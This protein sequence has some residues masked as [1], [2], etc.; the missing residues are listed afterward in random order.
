MRGGARTP[1]KEP[2]KTE[3]VR[4][5]QYGLTVQDISLRLVIS[6]SAV[7]RILR[8]RNI[9]YRKPSWNKLPDD[10]R[11]QAV[12][13]YVNEKHTIPE[14]A[15]ILGISNT[16]VARWLKAENVTRPMGEA[17]AIAVQKGRKKRAKSQNI[18][19]QSSK[20]GRWEFADSRWEVVRMSQLDTDQTVATWTR[21]VDRIPYVDK[22]GKNRY[23]APD[24][25]IVYTDGSRV[26][27]EIKPIRFSESD[28]TKIK[29][30][31]AIAAFSQLGINY[32]LVTE[33]MIGIDNI[34]KFTLDGLASITDEQRKRSRSK[35]I[36][37]RSKK[38]RAPMVQEKR[39]RFMERAK[40]AA[41]MYVSGMTLEEVSKVFNVSVRSICY[42]LDNCN[43]KRREAKMRPHQRIKQGD[44]MRARRAINKNVSQ[45]SLW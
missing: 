38:R 42:W 21:L 43:V 29:A 34:R 41:E 12:S 5:C 13:L 23:Y 40:K 3:V 31:A 15:S 10:L 44:R 28:D 30:T 33:D 35:R 45:T 18:P 22:N 14:T 6:E 7:R 19:W 27:E 16:C 8:D 26:V 11:H 20:T 25:L 4:L 9:E 37:E 17:F 32:K 36:A 24:F 2:I 1:V 39:S